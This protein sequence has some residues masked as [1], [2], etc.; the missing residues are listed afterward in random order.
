MASGYTRKVVSRCFT[1]RALPPDQT[2]D[3]K[4]YTQVA[5]NVLS[6]RRFT[7]FPS[8]VS[9]KALMNPKPHVAVVALLALCSGYAAAVPVHT[10]NANVSSWDV[11]SGQVNGNFSVTTDSAFAGVGLQLGIRAEQR[12]AGAVVPTFN[13]QYPLSGYVVNAGTDTT[14][15][16]PARAWWNFQFSIGSNL[17]ISTGAANGLDALTLQIEKIAGTNSTPSGT[18]I[19]DL[20]SA[21]PFIDDRNCPGTP[22]TPCAPHTADPTYADVYQASQ[23]PVFFPWFAPPY[24]L[25]GDETFAYRFTLTAT[26]GS[27]SVSTSMCVATAGLSC[28][29]AVSEPASLALVALALAA[30]GVTR[31][32][33]PV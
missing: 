32:R 24:S 30:V 22:P 25:D 28:A 19:F 27:A 16:N 31:R 4:R 20:L 1:Q 2:T 10:S 18:G 6:E 9:R 26:E 13:D 23:N 14:Q 8:A 3:R 7:L 15:P 33:R 29:T 5:W 17:P 11:G 12:S 21:R